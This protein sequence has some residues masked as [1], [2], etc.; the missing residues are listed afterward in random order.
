MSTKKTKRFLDLKLPLGALLTF[1]GIILTVYGVFSDRTI[2]QKSF[3]I[4]V[5]L[6][7]G[8]VL[9]AI[10]IALLLASYHTY[11]TK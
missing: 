8:I 3:G 6:F 10:G 9:F 11:R 7:W 2:Y 1:Y 4:D 5:N